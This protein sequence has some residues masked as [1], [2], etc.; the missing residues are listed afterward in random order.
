MTSTRLP[1]KVLALIGEQPSLQLQIDR[2]R[3]ADELDA[4]A[5]ATSEDPSDDPIVA[6]CRELQ[7]PIV[8]GPLLDVLER[9]RLAGEELGAEGIV[10]LTADCP[11]IDPAVVDRVVARWRA[12]DED[13]VG[14]C[15]EPRTYPVGMDTEVVSWAALRASAAEATD[16]FDREHV[17][18]FVRARPERFPA[19]RVDLEP[20]YGEVRLTLDTP[21]DLALLRD[22]AARVASD[23]GLPEI[24]DAL[25]AR[26][27][28]V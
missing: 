8:R 19:A 5:V 16:P 18:P 28:P 22:L 15:V 1:G 21:A 26:P 14:N 10:R 17:T 9:Y 3:R 6:L 12:G 20:A 23:A 4:L 11:F 25:G 27:D 2:L 24:L 7:I 13:F